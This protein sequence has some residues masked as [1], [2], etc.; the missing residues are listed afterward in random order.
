MLHLH[1]ADPLKPRLETGARKA[2]GQHLL[3]TGID[4]CAVRISLQ[5]EGSRTLPQFLVS[6]ASNAIRDKWNMRDMAYH[7]AFLLN[8]YQCVKA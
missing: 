8:A 5:A 6:T 3:A 1:F 4:I 7:H 2:P